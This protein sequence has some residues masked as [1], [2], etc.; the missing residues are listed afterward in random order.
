MKKFPEPDTFDGL[1][2]VFEGAIITARDSGMTDKQVRE[3]FAEAN[4]RVDE[5]PE[6]TP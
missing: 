4:R 5:L 1:I 2:E 3:A 6:D